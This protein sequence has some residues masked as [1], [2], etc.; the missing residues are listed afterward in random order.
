VEKSERSLK[1]YE[2]TFRMNS[3]AGEITK[4]NYIRIDNTHLSPE[5]V[6]QMIKERFD[7]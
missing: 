6:A 5:D 7:I 4:E 1:E 2:N 3:E